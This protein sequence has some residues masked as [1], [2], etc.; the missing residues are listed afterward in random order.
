[1]SHIEEEEFN[2]TAV[3]RAEA[4][5]IQSLDCYIVSLLMYLPFPLAS[6]FL[7]GRFVYGAEQSGGTRSP[8]FYTR[9]P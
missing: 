7:K 1:M 3:R 4:I 5:D 2:F 6:L 9:N 8:V